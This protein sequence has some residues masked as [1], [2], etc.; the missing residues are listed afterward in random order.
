MLE[1]TFLR[2]GE[3]GLMQAAHCILLLPVEEITYQCK[4]NQSLGSGEA[5]S[6]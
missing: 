5:R 4:L 2:E 6:A 3:D 1:V